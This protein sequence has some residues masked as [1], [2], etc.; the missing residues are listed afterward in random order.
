MG[1]TVTLTIYGKEV[2]VPEGTLIVNAAKM[3][4][5]DVPVFCY[6]P[7]M[8]PVGMCRMCLVEI[9][10]PVRDRITGDLLKEADGSPKISFGPKLETACTTPVSE[11]M[12][13]LG[14]TEKARRGRKDILEFLLT[15]HPL[16]CPIC[17]KGGEC[18]LQNLTMGFGPGESRYL[19]DEKMHLAKHVP[20]GEL[21]FLDRERCIQ[22]GRCVRFQDQIVDEPVIGFFNRGRSLEI[23]T[24]S[25]PGFDSYFSGNTTDICPVGAL[26][27]AD[28]RFRARP[29][30]LR[31]A[32]SICNQCP[33]GCNI[34][35]NVR[36]E[37]KSGGEWVIKRAMPR[38]NEGVN[39]IWICDKGRFGYHFTHTPERLLQPLV[40]KQGELVPATWEEAL[41][42]VAEHFKKASHGLLT[43][44]S[45][46]LS[47]EDLFNLRQLTSN[48]GGQSVLYSQMA[49]GDKVA[50]VG[51]GQ[52]TNFAAMGAGTAILVVASDLH[53][54]APIWW[55]RVKQA[56]E[57]GATLIV[58]N[59]RPT[60]LERYAAHVLRYPYG[61]EAA[62]VLTMLNSLSAKRPELSDAAKE[63]GRDQALQA[64]AKAFAEAE[65]GVVIYGS[66][67][68]GL[69]ASQALAQA[70]A[71]LLVA[72]NHS[73]RANNG[74][75][76]VWQ[77]SNDQGAWDMGF[78]PVEDLK[79]ALGSAK[80]LYVVAA[81]PAG[82]DSNLA[83]TA[84]FLVVQDLF[85]TPTARLA[86]VVL[87]VSAF[88]EREGT[89]T[90]GERRVQRFYPAVPEQAG[91]FSDFAVVAQIGRRLGLQLEGRLAGRVM[92]QIA[93]EVPDYS[94][95]SYAQLSEVS[96]QWP[97][98]GRGELYYGGTG[99]ENSQ[100]LGVQLAPTAQKGG[101]PAL[102]WLQPQ[103][104]V[105]PQGSLL[106]VP[107]TRLYD[108]GQTIWATE[109]LRQRIP[110]PFVSMSPASG[111][112]LGIAHGG[113]AS[114]VLGETEVLVVAR[115]DETLPDDVVLVPRSFGI[116]VSAPVAVTLK[117]V[118]P[119]VA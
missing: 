75:L 7:K 68:A 48:L 1:K 10:R 62:T 3:A 65:N 8:E 13:V 100:G 27:T 83:E 80:A 63:L 32:A 37:A 2:T 25:D 6:H 112:R 16:D 18:P 77:R 33:V 89:Y 14:E 91:L 84:D 19:Y 105:A 119:A 110:E 85:L 43:L 88:T 12:V 41:G 55:L 108:R 26:T 11:G 52:G 76:A 44:V 71:N 98:V 20:L 113:K 5:V 31:A 81:D 74:L 24:Y 15:S 96:E 78:R 69:V 60:R 59:P 50:Q 79:A 58:A 29:W 40:R 22:C 116:P 47:N 90:S 56:A 94:G 54:E 46:R 118:E 57:R 61:A 117:A 17:D 106:A 53:E 38:Q 103:E 45:G 21:I 82:D 92:D 93:R 102:G 67:G 42:L 95:L 39:E 28:F 86:D 9:G 109:L 30:E 64:A 23:V 111:A 49:G 34:T 73:G 115:L 101:A 35:F 36:R 66:E 70:C 4:G 107:A 72:T 51:L 99:Y 104:T 87:P 97:I 114:L